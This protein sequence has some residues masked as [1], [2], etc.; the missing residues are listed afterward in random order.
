MRM[1]KRIFSPQKKQQLR[2]IHNHIKNECGFLLLKSSFHI[3]IRVA[4]FVAVFVVYVQKSRFC[5]SQNYAVAEINMRNRIFNVSFYMEN[6]L[7][8][9]YEFEIYINWMNLMT[10][11]RFLN[12]H[13]IQREFQSYYGH[14]IMLDDGDGNDGRKFSLL[15]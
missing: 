3:F 10:D 11:S 14:L 9:I 13:Q 5:N 12:T 1:E 8:R 15:L 2:F 4:H 6:G 7:V